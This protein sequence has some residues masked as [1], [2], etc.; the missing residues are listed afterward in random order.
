MQGIK[1]FDAVID[2]LAP[3]TNGTKCNHK[4]NIYVLL[5]AFCSYVATIRLKNP[6]YNSLKRYK[7]CNVNNQQHHIIDNTN[8]SQPNSNKTNEQKIL[9]A[10]LLS[11]STIEKTKRGIPNLCWSGGQLQIE[12]KNS[13]NK[14]NR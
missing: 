11:D 8:I 9:L 5:Y 3:T 6:R 12:C 14:R 1:D 13:V 4:V 10:I 2:N 7:Y